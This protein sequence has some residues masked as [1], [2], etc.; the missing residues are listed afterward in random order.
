MRKLLK[1]DFGAFEL[2][3]CRS[4]ILF[5]G[6]AWH[7]EKPTSLLALR[8]ACGIGYTASPST[9]DPAQNSTEPKIIQNLT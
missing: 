3:F 5:L 7:G 1:K 4:I 9:H 8:A 6:S 2:V